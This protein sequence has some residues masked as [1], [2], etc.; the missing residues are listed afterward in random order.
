MIFDG[1]MGTMLQRYRLTEE[2]FRGLEF[3]Y[4][5][6]ENLLFTDHYCINIYKNSTFS[7]CLCETK[8]IINNLTFR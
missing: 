8:L 6:L 3:H 7:A 5:V 4:F 1:G 2:D